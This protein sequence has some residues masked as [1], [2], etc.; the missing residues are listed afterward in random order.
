MSLLT[1]EDRQLAAPEM[2]LDRY[3]P[4]NDVYYRALDHLRAFAVNLTARM[5]PKHVHIVRGHHQ[6]RSNSEIAAEVGVSGNTVSRVLGQ[7]DAQELLKTLRQIAI[8]IDGP[9]LAHR[10]HV[11][12]R[13]VVDNEVHDPNIAIQALKELNKVEGAYPTQAPTPPQVNIVI[14]QEQLPRTALDE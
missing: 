7:K 13:I 11:L 8:Q 10:K 2:L 3:S 14:N 1:D 9:N 6:G 4:E 12:W 5:R